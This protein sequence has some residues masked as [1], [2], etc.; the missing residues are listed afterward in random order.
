[1]RVARIEAA[2]FEDCRDQWQ[3]ADRKCKCRGEAKQHRQLGRL[4]LDACRLI[5]FAEKDWRAALT[6]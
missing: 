5:G 2:R 1:M 3:S 6:R 4:S